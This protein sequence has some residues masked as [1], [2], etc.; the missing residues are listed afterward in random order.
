MPEAPA[1]DSTDGLCWGCHHPLWNHHII[2][3]GLRLLAV[4]LP[5]VLSVS[6]IEK[7]ISKCNVWDMSPV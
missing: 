4:F 1:H 5:R 7:I 2:I 6:S 3:R